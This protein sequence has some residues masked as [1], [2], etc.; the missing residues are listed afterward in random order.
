MYLLPTG[1]SGLQQP[2]CLFQP[3][4]TSFMLNQSLTE[5]LKWTSPYDLLRYTSLVSHRWTTASL[6]DEVWICHLE[7][8][9][10]APCCPGLP[11]KWQ[12]RRATREGLKMVILRYSSYAVFDCRTEK[13]SHYPKTGVMKDI[14]DSVGT[15]GPDGR[16]IWTGGRTLQGLWGIQSTIRVGSEELELLADMKYPRTKHAAVIVASSLYVFGG[17]HKEQ[18]PVQ[19]PATDSVRCSSR[20]VWKTCECLSISPAAQWTSLPCMSSA[21]ASLSACAHGTDVYL[22][23][24]IFTLQIDLF[25]TIRT[26]F[27]SVPITFPY[28]TVLAGSVLIYSQGIVL[29]F[30]QNHSDAGIVGVDVGRVLGGAREGV[31]GLAAGKAFKDRVYVKYFGGAVGKFTLGS[32]NFELLTLET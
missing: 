23:A 12:Y 11:T 31:M 8:A 29:S 10:Y 22:C 19:R 26:S 20:V 32:G 15:L 5:V 6:S 1:I 24:S 18:F 13:W 17:Q 25:D 2:I 27:R 16:V 28:N 30:G 4:Q 21:K 9:G 7:E 14:V 3:L